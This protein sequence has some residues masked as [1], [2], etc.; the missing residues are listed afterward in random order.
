[1][2]KDSTHYRPAFTL[3]ELL[4]VIAIIGMLIG[5]LLPAVQSARE[6][7]RRMQCANKLKQLSLAIHNFAD[8]KEGNIPYGWGRPASE[9]P[10][11]NDRTNR[12]W[13]IQAERWSGFI[14]LLPYFEQNAVYEKFI[15]ANAF[16]NNN[17]SATT[18]GAADKTTLPLTLATG[19][20]VD[21]P[22]TE[23]L[24]AL[25]C[26]SNG[27]VIK[28]TNYTAPTTYRFNCGDNPGTYNNAARFR[29]PFV[30]RARLSLGSISDGLSNTLAL[31]EKAVETIPG[32][33]SKNVKTEATV[34]RAT[35]GPASV[36][37]WTVQGIGDRRIC[38]NSAAGGEYLFAGSTTAS[39]THEGYRWGWQWAGTHYHVTF[40][41]TLPPNS[42]SCYNGLADYQMLTSPTS[43]HSGGVNAALMDGAVK[44]VSDSVDSGTANAFPDPANP[45]GKSPFGI[46]G[47][48][49]TRSGGESVTL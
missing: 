7:A 29:G 18:L 38:Q 17:W 2:R 13:S 8:S 4:V 47:A 14:E 11:G 42:A 15:A 22:R 34:H 44:F 24:A 19:E 1:M 26:P 40:T 32:T 48:M 33:V 23:Y 31:S 12:A 5:L 43:F 25:I 6:A 36:S 28:P 20:L 9:V 39:G 16:G 21:N 45:S 49:G 10:A 46:W 35:A 3:V 27:N 41:T 30:Y 37:G